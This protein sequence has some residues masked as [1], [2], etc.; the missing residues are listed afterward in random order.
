MFLDYLKVALWMMRA[1]PVRAVLSLLG[2]FIGVLALVVIL[3]IHE[4]AR[5]S[6]DELY[7]TEGVR[8]FIVMPSFDEATM[9]MGNLTLDDATRLAQSPDILSVLP[10]LV[11]EREVRS[12]HGSSKAPIMGIDAAFIPVYRVPLLAGRV[13]LDKEVFFRQPVCLL[14]D[15]GEHRLF[16]LGG[17]VG[18]MIDIQG[19]PFE[20]VGVVKWNSDISQRAFA[21]G[22]PEIL[23]PV[24]W[25]AKERDSSEDRGRDN[26]MIPMIEIRAAPEKPSEAVVKTI[27]ATLSHHDASRSKLYTIES[28]EEYLQ[29]SRESV[30][31]MLKSLLAIAAIS[32]LVGGIGVANVM[33]TSVTERTREIG[34]RKALGARRHDIL[35][36]FLVESSVLTASGGVLAVAIGGIGIAVLPVFLQTPLP[37][38]IPKL[39]VAGCL[40][41]TFAIGLI[42]GAYPASRAAALS[43]AEALRYE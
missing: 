33:L 40:L 18:Q 43:P 24:S 19:T 36:Q 21:G 12:L 3:A 14:T 29:G 5:H 13:L 16:P 11:S 37:L 27:R 34:V 30:A 31:R 9:K 1:K 6:I 10:R 23:A 25:L 4:G 26:F 20:V 41:L 35:F 2:I 22:E 42:A 8:V 7:R 38:I 17:A 32:L 39:P 15:K 28:L